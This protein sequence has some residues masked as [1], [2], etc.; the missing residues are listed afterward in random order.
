MCGWRQEEGLPLVP[1]DVICYA[2]IKALFYGYH[3]KIY[4]S[5]LN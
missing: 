3:F 2:H 5:D 4:K 1:V